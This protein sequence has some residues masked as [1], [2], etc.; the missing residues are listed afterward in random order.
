MVLNPKMA[1]PNKTARS[2]TEYVQSKYKTE[3]IENAK[4]AE[5]YAG[6]RF[7]GLTP[8]GAEVWISM[9]I[10]KENL[11]LKV[12]STH[13]LNT[14]L[15]KGAILAEK[16]VEIKKGTHSTSTTEDLIRR[17]QK[18]AGG[19]VEHATIKHLMR[20]MNAVEMKFEKAY[21]KN[22]PSSTLFSYCA[23]SIYSGDFDMERGDTSCGYISKYWDFPSGEYFT[24]ESVPLFVGQFNPYIEEDDETLAEIH[25]E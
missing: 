11:D 23:W 12:D 20:L 15:Q 14:L 13:D 21:V 18:N 3:A 10:D 24:V 2:N 5:I 7:L 9:E 6:K 22:K 19:K 4:N 16:R 17:A 25:A 1:D 8:K